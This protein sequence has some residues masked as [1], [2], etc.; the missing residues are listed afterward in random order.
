MVASRNV[1][2]VGFAMLRLRPVLAAAL[3]IAQLAW[4]SA[5]LAQVCAVRSDLLLCGASSRTLAQLHS[6]GSYNE[7]SSCSP[8]GNT[9]AMF[10]SRYAT[11]SGNG[12]AW[13]AYLNAGG[14]IITEYSNGAL[15]YNEIY[16]TAYP[17]GSQAG[18][19]ADNPMPSA[20]LNLSNP[21]WVQNNIP[22]TPAGQEGCGYD[23]SALV[24]GEASVTALGARAADTAFINFA[25]RPQGPGTLFLLEA[26]WQDV[27]TVPFDANNLAFLDALI[28]ECGTAPVRV[29]S[30][31]PVPVD[32]PLALGALAAVLG[33]FGAAFARLRRRRA[34]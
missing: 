32:G 19:C 6:S 7:V 20:K 5:A 18:I 11:I 25:I 30:V 16:G 28:T 13:L 15:V 24:A 2:A 9:Q 27:E 21:F 33:L 34:G 10:V 1:L 22:A 29:H 3:A 8:D 12:A 26:D 31:T 4:S 23:L 17:S 14:R